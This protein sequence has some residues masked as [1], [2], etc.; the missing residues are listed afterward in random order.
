MNALELARKSAPNNPG[1]YLLKLADSILYV[2]KASSLFFRLSNWHHVLDL[3]PS[4]VAPAVK[5]DVLPIPKINSVDLSNIEAIFIAKLRP[6]L[7]Q[8]TP[9][10]SNQKTKHLNLLEPYMKSA[11]K[12]NH[13]ELAMVNHPKHSS[14]VPSLVETFRGLRGSM[15]AGTYT[16]NDWE[17][18]ESTKAEAMDL[19]CAFRLKPQEIISSALALLGAMTEANIDPFNREDQVEIGHSHFIKL[20]QASE[21]HSDPMRQQLLDIWMTRPDR[22]SVETVCLSVLQKIPVNCST[23]DLAHITHRINVTYGV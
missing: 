5:L 19:A 7:N 6:Q 18:T 22:P 21:L 11:I 10:I 15:T 4:E 3:L 14:A 2:G 17:L 13:S 20:I 9:T 23:I 12:P 8:V 16:K 1:L